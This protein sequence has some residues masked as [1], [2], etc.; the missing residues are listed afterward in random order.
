M[1]V[2]NTK[3]K[4]KSHE[5]DAVICIT[6]IYPPPPTDDPNIY[7]VIHRSLPCVP[8]HLRKHD[9]NGPITFVRP[10]DVKTQIPHLP[11]PPTQ[12][13]STKNS[14]SPFSNLAVC[15]DKSHLCQPCPRFNRIHSTPQLTSESPDSS[16]TMAPQ[17]TRAQI[18]EKLRGQIAEGKTIVGAGAGI[19]LSAKFV[20]AGGGDLIIIY[21][22]GRFRM[23]GRGSLAGLMPYGNANEIVVD[24]VL[25][26]RLPPQFS[27]SHKY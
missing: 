7:F 1:V 2:E 10:N 15:F 12:T 16:S 24:M 19:G 13:D 11:P 4:V 23:A 9:D 3:E 18:L 21:N 22:S 25:Y 14:T 20:E 17:L 5:T 8:L 27:L 6:I 26:S